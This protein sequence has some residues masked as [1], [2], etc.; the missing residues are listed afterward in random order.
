[1]YLTYSFEFHSKYPVALSQTNMVY[2]FQFTTISGRTNRSKGCSK[3][4]KATLNYNNTVI[5]NLYLLCIV[6][7]FLYYCYLNYFHHHTI[8]IMSFSENNINKHY[9]H[10]RIQQWEIYKECNT[11]LIPT[12]YYYQIVLISY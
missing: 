12:V 9:Y 5:N 10:K 7:H 2:F 4:Q 6:I 11:V 1:M 8:Q 3:T